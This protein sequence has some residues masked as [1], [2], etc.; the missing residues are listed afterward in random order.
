ML[1]SIGQSV[2]AFAEQMPDQKPPI[3][4]KKNEYQGPDFEGQP[5]GVEIYE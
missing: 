1:V 4:S 5:T 2:D 3:M